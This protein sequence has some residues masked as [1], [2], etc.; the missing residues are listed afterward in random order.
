MTASVDLS[1]PEAASRKVDEERE[2]M[3]LDTATHIKMARA[4]RA[5]YQAKVELAVQDATAKMDHSRRVYTFIVDYGQNM[6]LPIYNKKQ[7]GC[8]YYFSPLSVFNL[9]VVN[10]NHAYNDRR[11]YEHLHC[12]VY[13]ERVG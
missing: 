1:P 13:H 9:G 3:L 4:Q 11:L 5:L 7:P 12:H 10:H 8:T 2:M 6:E